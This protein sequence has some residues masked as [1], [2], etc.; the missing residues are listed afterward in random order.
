MKRIFLL[1][2]IT[3]AVAT[4]FAEC[5]FPYYPEFADVICLFDEVTPLMAKKAV[6]AGPALGFDP[7]DVV[8]EPLLIRDVNGMPLC[9]MVGTYRGD[10][11]DVV[12]RWN[13]L[14]KKVNA[15]EKI[16]AREL[17]EELNFFYSEEIRSLFANESLSAYT[18]LGPTLGGSDK[19]PPFAFSGYA[20]AYANAKEMFGGESFYFTRIV[21]AGWAYI[22]IFEFENRQGEKIYVEYDVCAEKKTSVADLY[23]TEQ[24]IRDWLRRMTTDVM[25][26]PEKGEEKRT[27]WQKR[28]EAITDELA[29]NEFP[30]IQEFRT[31][32]SKS[33]PLDDYEIEVLPEVPDPNM[34]LEGPYNTCWSWAV[35]AVFVYHSQ[36][37]KYLT[38]KQDWKE[39]TI[40]SFESGTTEASGTQRYCKAIR[41]GYYDLT[42]DWYEKIHPHEWECCKSANG[43]SH[44]NG[45]SGPTN[46]WYYDF[47]SWVGRDDPAEMYI[48]HHREYMD[49][50]LVT[51]IWETKRP[52]AAFIPNMYGPNQDHACPAIGYEKKTTGERNLLLHDMNGAFYDSYRQPWQDDKYAGIQH[53]P[54]NSGPGPTAAPWVTAFNVKKRG[55]S[56]LINWSVGSTDDVKGFNVY[57]IFPSGSFARVNG[58]LIGVKSPADK[59]FYFEDKDPPRYPN[60]ALEL[61]RYTEDTSKFIYT[62]ES[63]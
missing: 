41:K 28:V 54:P 34:S 45:Y 10:D 19:S 49:W 12:R 35:A 4:A 31:N 42:Y 24:R 56:R 13:T 2:A 52:I 60:Y 9:Y 53:E 46:Q 5:D 23:E 47:Y 26:N 57:Y 27:L 14:I 38:F 15:R 25:K 6:M 61:V 29:E 1:V 50:L 32:G 55:R 62:E 7:G 18:F 20:D 30:E 59:E 51:N 48:T 39:P 16:D 63:F 3:A 11:L 21:G 22:Q 37:H 17:A 44:V 40:P 43:Y 33:A 36:R 8:C 58:E